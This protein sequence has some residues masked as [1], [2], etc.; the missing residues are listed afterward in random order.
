MTETA[1]ML[2]RLARAIGGEPDRNLVLAFE[3]SYHELESARAR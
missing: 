2:S 3:G 1:I